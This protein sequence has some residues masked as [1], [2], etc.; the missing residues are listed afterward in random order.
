[1]FYIGAQTHVYQK[2]DEEREEGGTPSILGAIRLGLVMQEDYL[3]L[4]YM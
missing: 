4:I 2:H 1:M 3:H